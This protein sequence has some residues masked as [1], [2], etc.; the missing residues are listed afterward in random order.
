M[1]SLVLKTSIEEFESLEV[2][3]SVDVNSN[4]KYCTSFISNLKTVCFDCESNMK[5]SNLCFYP[6]YPPERTSTIGIVTQNDQMI[7]TIQKIRKEK[8]L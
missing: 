5:I 6:P 4:L 2:S 3:I 8:T 7:I 1:L